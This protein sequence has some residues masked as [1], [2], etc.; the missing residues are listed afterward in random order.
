MFSAAEFHIPSGFLT[1]LPYYCSSSHGPRNVHRPGSNC[2]AWDATQ[3]AWSSYSSSLRLSVVIFHRHKD[4]PANELKWVHVLA[5]EHLSCL[6]KELTRC[7][8]CITSPHKFKRFSRPRH[9]VHGIL[10]S[11]R[12]KK[13]GRL[14]I[15]A[16]L[17]GVVGI[18]HQITA[19]NR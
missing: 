9:G 12:S 8:H 17:L 13:F 3:V 4:D 16:P 11:R 10:G 7:V 1:K 19:R 14:A 18:V 5:V 2:L 15:L 6:R